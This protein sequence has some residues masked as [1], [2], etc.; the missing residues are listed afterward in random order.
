MPLEQ[1][2]NML[3]GCSRAAQAGL[4]LRFGLERRPRGLE[5]G[6]RAL[7]RSTKTRLRLT[8]RRQDAALAGDVAHRD[9]LTISRIGLERGEDGAVPQRGVGGEEELLREALRV[10]ARPVGDLDA[11]QGGAA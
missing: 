3:Q 6:P 1:S 2:W 4:A 9:R 5:R 11:A 10:L 7:E 8:E